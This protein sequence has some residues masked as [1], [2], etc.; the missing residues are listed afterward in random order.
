MVLLYL[1]TALSSF[2]IPHPGPRPVK[3]IAGSVNKTVI[4]DMINNVRAKGCKCGD[5]YYYPAAPIT[6]NDKLEDAATKH[7]NDMWNRRYFSHISPEGTKPG[8]RIDNAGYTWSAFGENIAYGYKTEKEVVEG[9]IKSP[10]HCKNIMNKNFKETGV[11]RTG[12]YWTQEFG[13]KR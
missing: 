13:T 5:T 7:S 4:L 11:A 9:W 6:W 10:G 1:F 8:T 12:L 2:I 3:D